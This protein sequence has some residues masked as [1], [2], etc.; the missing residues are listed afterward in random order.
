MT[1]QPLGLLILATSS[2]SNTVTSHV[3]NL[4][5]LT[6]AHSASKNL[7]LRNRTKHHAPD[8]PYAD[9]E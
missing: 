5:P 1:D 6:Q 9:R 4:G 8:S 3:R 2:A 7:H